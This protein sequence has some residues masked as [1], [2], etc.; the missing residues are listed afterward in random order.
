MKI[1]NSVNPKDFIII[2]RV[3]T[4]DEIGLL[5]KHIN[6]KIKQQMH[7]LVDESEYDYLSHLATKYDKFLGDIVHAKWIPDD[8]KKAEGICWE[9]YMQYVAG[10]FVDSNEWAS[11][12][13]SIG[14]NNSTDYKE[15]SN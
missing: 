3:M 10:T 4:N 1:I 15:A 5:L 7:K 14:I 13:K 2:D 8:N 11:L 6:I 9:F 12:K